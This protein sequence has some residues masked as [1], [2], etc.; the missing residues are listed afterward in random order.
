MRKLNN[1]GFAIS[2]VLYGLLVVLILITTLIIA[3]MSSSR[4]SSKEFTDNI[5]RNL[6]N[7]PKSDLIDATICTNEANAFMVN[8]FKDDSKDKEQMCSD[9]ILNLKEKFVSICYEKGA[10]KGYYDCNAALSENGNDE[11]INNLYSTCSNDP[12]DY[13]VVSTVVEK[14]CCFYRTLEYGGDS[15]SYNECLFKS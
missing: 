4:K 8:E 10:S 6:E 13:N 1:K 9:I 5:T 2:T 12:D 14:S 3:T 7:V 15:S 11:V